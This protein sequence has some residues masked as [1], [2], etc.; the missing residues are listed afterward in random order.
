MLFRMWPERLPILTRTKGI[1]VKTL[2][3]SKM[4]ALG[5][6]F[7]VI[8]TLNQAFTP[9]QILIQE[10]SDRHF[11]IGFDQMLI[12]SP[13]KDSSYD[14]H[15]QIFNADGQEVGQCG[16][17]AR[18]AARYIHRYLNPQKSYFHI[19]TQ[20][21]DIHL[22]LIH[23]LVK[24]R[25]PCPNHHPAQIPFDTKKVQ[26]SYP[27]RLNDGLTIDIH[28][29]NVGNPHAI[30]LV[31][32]IQTIDIHKIG[33]QVENHPRFAEK[34]NVNFMQIINHQEIALRVWERGCGETLACGSGALATAAAARLYHHMDSN[35]TLHLKGG[36]LKVDWPKLNGPIFQIGPAQEIYRGQLDI[37]SGHGG[38]IL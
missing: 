29:I 35:I 20:T 6:D 32:D 12:I 17:G 23:D 33:P 18:C 22:E 4:Q 21:T 25:L 26:D 37:P 36:D 5:N 2:N 30:I 11:G 38:Y 34:C 24:M 8:E 27:L 19:R 10:W 1:M 7:M 16:N 13:P 15:Y 14:Y 9:N 31:N 28:V 3:F